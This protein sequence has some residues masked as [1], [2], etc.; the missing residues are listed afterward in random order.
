MEVVLQTTLPTGT[1]IHVRVAA[2]IVN[3]CRRTALS[4]RIAVGVRVAD[5][6]SIME[7]LAL[8]AEGGAL[9]EIRSSGLDAVAVLDELRDL[10]R[11]GMTPASA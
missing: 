10:L 9:L 7:L 6:R 1:A 5:G 4:I 3:I 8:G 2:T 11:G